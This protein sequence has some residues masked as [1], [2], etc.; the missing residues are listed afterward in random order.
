MTNWSL[1][2]HLK[3]NKYLCH[4]LLFSM[5]YHV[6]TGFYTTVTHLI[7][8][9]PISLITYSYAYLWK[10]NSYLMITQN[11]TWVLICTNL[12]LLCIFNWGRSRSLDIPT[13]MFL[14]F[15]DFLMVEQIFLSPQLKGSVNISNKLVYMSCLRSCLTLSR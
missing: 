13:I 15:L 2:F 12:L 8:L 9:S 11:F 4:A 1:S 10:W 6:H 3:V 7:L 14:V 5:P